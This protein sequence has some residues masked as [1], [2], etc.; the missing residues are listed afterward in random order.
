MQNSSVP[1]EP[2]VVAKDIEGNEFVV[3]VS[4]LCWRPSAYGIVVKDGALLTPIHFG[5]HNLP[6]GG[7]EFGEMPEAAVIREV[8]E[9][10]GI[11]VKNPRLAAVRTTF[12]KL[13]FVDDEVVQSLLLFYVCDFAGGEFSKENFDED[14]QKYAEMAEWLPLEKVDGTPFAGSFDWRPIVTEAIRAKS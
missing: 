9:E 4:K 6:G 13:P 2:T 10:T 1:S 12:F 11:E 5:K 14:E 8:K 3:P 7:M